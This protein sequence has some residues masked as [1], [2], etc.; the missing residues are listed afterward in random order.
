MSSERIVARESA[1]TCTATNFCWVMWRAIVVHRRPHRV[2]PARAF[3]SA[4]GSVDGSRPYVHESIRFRLPLE[5]KAPSLTTARILGSGWTGQL[6]ARG[7]A[8]TAS[9]GLASCTPHRFAASA[10]PT[11]VPATTEVVSVC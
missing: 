4:G 8:P 5:T 6:M 3:P 11:K 1:S 10:D 9:A 7:I 2:L